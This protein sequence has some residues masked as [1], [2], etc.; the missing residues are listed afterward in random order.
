MKRE[1]M[2]FVAA[3]GL[4]AAATASPVGVYINDD[5]PGTT[6]SATWQNYSAGTGTVTVA[7]SKMTGTAPGGDRSWVLAQNAYAV[8]PDLGQTVVLSSSNM[9]LG[10]WC[11]DTMWGLTDSLGNDISLRLYGTYY[12]E[13]VINHGGTSQSLD[14]VNPQY[15]TYQVTGA[16]SISWSPTQV[17]LISANLGTVFDSTVQTTDRNNVAWTLPTASLAPMA[18]TYYSSFSFDNMKLEVIP[19]PASVLLLGL[20][21]AG[22][23]GRKQQ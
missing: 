19:E 1:L 23:W 20:A 21:L 8:H 2:P 5:F 10:G 9:E 6:L 3:L 13:M 16:W 15:L 7:D 17:K 11:P 4:T 12:A 14:L 22:L 18:R